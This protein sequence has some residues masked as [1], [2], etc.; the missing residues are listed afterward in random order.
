MSRRLRWD[1][2][3]L[4]AT[5]LPGQPVPPRIRLF[6]DF[7]VS[8]LANQV[9][10]STTPATDP[11]RWMTCSDPGAALRGCLFICTDRPISR[12]ISS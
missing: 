3:E 11:A 5:F 6:V 1:G 9:W 12:S 10:M 4:F 7:M 8:K 2:I